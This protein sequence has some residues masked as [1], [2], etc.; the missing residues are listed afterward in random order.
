LHAGVGVAVLV[1]TQVA[2]VVEGRGEVWKVDVWGALCQPA[3]DVQRLLVLLAGI[4]VA[5]LDAA[6]VTE[7]VEGRGD[8]RMVR[9][10]ARQGERLLVASPAL[11]EVIL[12]LMKT[13]VRE[14]RLP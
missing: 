5:V 12:L 13:P 4:G 14:P 1:A 7:V 3:S 11:C 6:Q 9:G 2:E 10:Q 8:I